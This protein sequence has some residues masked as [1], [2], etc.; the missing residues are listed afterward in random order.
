MIKS[1][2]IYL[3]WVFL[4]DPRSIPECP[5]DVDPDKVW[6]LKK[7]FPKKLLPDDFAK[8]RSSCASVRELSIP[9][10]DEL[11]DATDA[12]EAMIQE[13]VPTSLQSKATPSSEPHVTLSSSSQSVDT[14]SVAKD[15]L[16][17]KQDSDPDPNKKA[18]WAEE[19]AGD[20]I[21]NVTKGRRLPQLMT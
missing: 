2:M 6:V 17:G 16:L 14:A 21:A 3:R 15:R 4:L 20:G 7:A 10:M 9:G 13:E 8:I 1:G 19:L 12:G 11:V 18:D 5:A